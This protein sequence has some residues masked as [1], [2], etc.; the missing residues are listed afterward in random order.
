MPASSKK[1]AAAKVAVSTDAPILSRV[2]ELAKNNPDMSLPVVAVKALLET[3]RENKA[4]TQAEF[5]V[6]L[7]A[8]CGS[9]KNSDNNN[10]IAM[11]AGADLFLTMIKNNSFPTAVFEDWKREIIQTA[12]YMVEKFATHRVQAAEKGLRFIKDD[13]VILVHSYSR[14][15]MTLLHRASTTNKRFKVFVTESRPSYSGEKAVRE[16]RK[17]NIPAELISDAA[18]GYVIEQVDYVIVGAE[19]VTQNGGVINQMGTYQL[20]VVAKA[21]NKPFYVV[22]ESYKFAKIFPLNQYDLPIPAPSYFSE[23]S[24]ESSITPTN[25]SIDYTPPQYISLLFTNEGVLT[26]SRVSEELI[27]YTFY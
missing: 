13:D 5:L 19:G 10:K 12:E 8:V 1:K 14:V 24:S 22:A 16:L 7:D 3:M 23:T 18:V 11:I 17:A 4:S 20:A 27:K 2:K 26:P 15:V 25:P 9:L 6:N 21:A